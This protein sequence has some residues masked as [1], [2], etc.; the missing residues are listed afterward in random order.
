MPIVKAATRLNMWPSGL[1]LSLNVSNLR[2][3]PQMVR[4]TLRSLARR[5]LSVLHETS[6]GSAQSFRPSTGR[7]CSPRPP[8]HPCP[9]TSPAVPRPNRGTP[10]SSVS[11]VPTP[12]PH[13]HLHTP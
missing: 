3:V 13:P 7:A 8:P 11:L 5:Y 9:Q 4:S 12:P 10:P 1:S 6:G 2:R